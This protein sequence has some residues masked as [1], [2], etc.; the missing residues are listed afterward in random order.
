MEDIKIDIEIKKEC[1]ENAQEFERKTSLENILTDLGYMVMDNQL[2]KDG[3]FLGNLFYQDEI[4]SKIFKPHNINWEDYIIARFKPDEVFI[5]EA[6]KK[7]YIIEKKLPETEGNAVEKFTSFDFR[8]KQ[9]QKLF[10]T[11]GYKVKI[12]Y[13]LHHYY[14]Q[15]K[16]CQLLEYI[17]KGRCSYFFDDDDITD[18]LIYL[19]IL[20]RRKKLAVNKKK[21]YTD[22]L[23]FETL[24]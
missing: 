9:F 16:Y 7:V 2:T 11:L 10:G 18:E 24:F 21:P 12:C 15:S 1:F 19:G 22:F 17:K 4:Y 13:V 3:L 5:D 14:R 20:N 23:T 6:K 8:R